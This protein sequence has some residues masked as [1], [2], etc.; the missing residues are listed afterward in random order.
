MHNGQPLQCLLR[1]RLK[2]IQSAS[3]SRV[4]LFRKLEILTQSFDGVAAGPLSPPVPAPDLRRH[5]SS[6]EDQVHDL[7][8]DLIHC[9]NQPGAETHFYRR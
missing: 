5:K 2:S 3:A 1:Q 8:R 7:T 4:S 9:C 6:L